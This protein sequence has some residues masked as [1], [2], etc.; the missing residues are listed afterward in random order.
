MTYNNLSYRNK[1]ILLNSLGLGAVFVLIFFVFLPN[2]NKIKII[3]QTI[4]DKKLEFQRKADR[5]MQVPKVVLNLNEMEPRVNK[6]ADNL[7]KKDE[8]INFITTLE[9]LANEHGVVARMSI[10][11]KK[12]AGKFQKAPMQ[13]FTQGEYYG[14][15]EYL[16]SLEAIKYYS[17]ITSI[18]FSTTGSGDGLINLTVG[19]DTYW[20]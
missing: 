4:T 7:I 8:E 3:E 2:V 15:L 10:G 16:R 1:I 12:Q 17:N 14:L 6:I 9:N 18:E 13:I 19:L 20:Q 5:L 11:E